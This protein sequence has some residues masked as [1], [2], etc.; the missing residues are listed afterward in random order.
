VV[1]LRPLTI[2]LRRSS[3]VAA[4]ALFTALT[5]VLFFSMTG[6]WTHGSGAWDLQWNGLVTWQRNMLVFG[7]P[8]VLGAG[9]LLGARDNRSKIGELLSTTARP[10]TLRALPQAGALALAVAVGYLAVFVVGAVQVIGNDGLFTFTWL[11]TLLVGLL[12]VVGGGLLGMGLGRVLPS[13]LT[14]PAVAVVGL[15]VSAGFEI[16]SGRTAGESQLLPNRIALLGPALEGTSNA[17]GT[18][19][20]RVDLAQALWFAGMAAT[21]FLLLVAKNVRSRLLAALPILLGA[22]IALPI[23]PAVAAQN[24]VL[25]PTSVAL[26]CDDHGARV[27]VTKAHENL[28]GALEVP[29]REAL[30]ELSK[31]PGG[32]TSVEELPAPQTLYGRLPVPAGVVPIDFDDFGPGA[33]SDPER[34]RLYLIAGAGTRA[35]TQQNYTNERER[36][37]RTVAA[38]WTAGEFKSLSPRS[39]DAPEV[40]PRAESTWRTFSALPANVQQDRILAMRAAASTCSG[41][42]LTVLTGE[43]AP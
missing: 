23:L 27:C 15:V 6:P 29:A 32:P 34:L 5:L 18:L 13:V 17:F 25:E 19:A 10:A 35:C 21:G 14:P 36:V 9:A 4:S 39:Y 3:A 26:V 43:P 1:N 20:G 28:L 8:L 42:L 33:M 16:I 41:D 37:A 7:W 24:F 2:E 22:A 30:R 12:V 11:P 31:V 38:A 40:D